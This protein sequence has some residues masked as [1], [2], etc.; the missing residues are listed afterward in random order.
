LLPAWICE[1]VQPLRR[2]D[3]VTLPASVT[4][5]RQILLFWLPLA[6]S[7]LLMGAEGPVLQAVIAR[8]ADIETQLAAFGIV[9]SL[10]IAIESPVIMLLATSTAL[11][12]NARNYLTLRRF[13]IRVNLMATAISVL[14]A[15]TPAYDLIVRT[16]MGIPSHIADAALP[17]M[18]IMTLWAAAIGVRRFYQGVMI[19]NGKTRSIG[20]GTVVRLAGSGG[21]GILLAAFSG[22]PGVY[23]GGI[24]LMTGVLAEA[25]FITWAVRPTVHRILAE[26]E[27]KDAR[28]YSLAEVL[29]YH[30]P[31]AVTSLLTLLAQP[32]IGAGLARMSNPEENLAAW[33]VVWGIVFLFRSPTF[34]LPEAVI[35]LISEPR[36]K[37]AVWKFCCR[38]GV[39]C[40]VAMLLLAVT[41]LSKFYLQTIAGLPDNL[42]RYVMP[43]V[44]LALALP[45]INSIHSWLRGLLM[46]AHSTHVIY[47]GM[48]LNLVAT[49]GILL[50][51]GWIH[52]PGAQTAIVAVT[53]ALILEVLYLHKASMCDG[54]ASSANHAR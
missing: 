44:G 24:A 30:A 26:D 5:Q 3:T 22:L 4:T 8:L 7:W 16:W 18:K 20:Y 12:T 34:A 6:A 41:P 47:W 46:A 43:A 45:F 51:G 2:E 50:A 1:N 52:A 37:T 39:G 38:I 10:E 53:A 40:S 11:S 28:I 9:M 21:S 36:L 54:S 27:D 13:M 15:F 17:G 48:G 42:S 19:R 35:A 14:I 31:L 29:R 33:P 32:L 49:V 25:A 23:V